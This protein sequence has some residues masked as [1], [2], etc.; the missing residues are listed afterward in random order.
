[1]ERLEEVLADGRA[2]VILLDN[3]NPAKLRQA[4]E[5]VKKE[6]KPYVIEAS[7]IGGNDLREVAETGVHFI[8][9]SSLVE[10]AKKRDISKRVVKL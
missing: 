4:V 8:S 9:L 6:K 3:M 7:G 2:D 5:R 10:G 1:M